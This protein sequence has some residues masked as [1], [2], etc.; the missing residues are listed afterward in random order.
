MTLRQ[1]KMRQVKSFVLRAG[2]IT[3]GQQ[4]SLESLLPVHG[5]EHVSSLVDLNVVFGRD[6][7]KIIEIGFGMGKSTSQTAIANPDFDY[8]GIEVHPPGVGSLLMEIDQYK[9]DNVKVIRYDAVKVIKDM[10]MDNSIHGFH[11]FF[12]D[13]WHKKRHNKRRIIQATFIELL[14]SKLKPGGYIHLA[15][16]WE[17]YAIWMLDILNSNPKLINTSATGDYVPR[18]LQRPETKFEQRGLSLGHG[19]WDLIFKKQ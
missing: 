15:T 1:V 10:I 7:P 11:I 3:P 17:D 19:V 14:C 4:K 8:L 6:S 2:K 18:P 16:D 5:I 13:P 9:I 12:P